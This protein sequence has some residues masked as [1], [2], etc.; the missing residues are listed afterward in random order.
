MGIEKKGASTGKRSFRKRRRP[1]VRRHQM[2]GVGAVTPGSLAVGLLGVFSAIYFAPWKGL[3]QE[4]STSSDDMSAF[5][6][7]A[8]NVLTKAP[9]GPETTFG[10]LWKD[11]RC[12]I[13]FFRRFG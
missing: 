3:N 13:I 12:V 10:E 11:H 7:I 4:S 2:R 5:Q 6:K 9:A 8:Q 1:N